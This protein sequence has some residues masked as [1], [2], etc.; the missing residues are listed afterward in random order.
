MKLIK[1]GI[2]R[3]YKGHDYLV[4]GVATHSETEEQLVVYFSLY[5][6]F[7]LRVRPLKM[8]V[9]KVVVKGKKLPRF[10]FIRQTF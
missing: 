5:E 9:E 1:H 8:F 3:H 7:H 2:Y 6:K 10:K 4:L